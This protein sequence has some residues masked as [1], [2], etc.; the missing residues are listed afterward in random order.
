MFLQWS[1]STWTQ[2]SPASQ[3]SLPGSCTTPQTLILPPLASIY[4]SSY[5]VVYHLFESTAYL[6]NFKF[7]SVSLIVWVWETDLTPLRTYLSKACLYTFIPQQLVTGLP[8]LMFNSRVESYSSCLTQLVDNQY[9]IDSQWKIV[10]WMD[11][12]IQVLNLSHV[13]SP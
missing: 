8:C 9:G 11:E 6:N 10:N 12:C 5:S 4:V 1:D 3:T 13:L 7:F 2:R